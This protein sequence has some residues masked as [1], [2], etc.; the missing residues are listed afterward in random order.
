V[1]RLELPRSDC[2]I[3]RQSFDILHLLPGR[4]QLLCAACYRRLLEVGD[5]EAGAGSLRAS[6]AWARRTG[7]IWRMAVR[8]ACYL[9]LYWWAGE[10]STRGAICAGIMLAD[11]VT[12]CLFSVFEIPFRRASVGIETTAYLFALHFAGLSREMS[13]LMDRNIELV[14]VW[15][16]VT[17]V[18][19]FWIWWDRFLQAASEES[20]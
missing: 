15:G 16:L 12:W 14:F 2:G 20:G 5:R 1:K 4:D 18:F 9:V 8:A 19:K 6:L 7:W 3:C 17:A 10:S 13:R 11:L